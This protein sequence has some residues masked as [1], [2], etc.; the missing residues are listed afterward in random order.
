MAAY[1]GYD[2]PS[3]W[4]ARNYEH[5]SEV[6]AVESFFTKIGNK[7]NV[8]DIG[9]G[10][11]RLANT[12]SKFAKSITLVEPSRSLL[13][14]ARMTLKGQANLHLVNSTL[15]NMDSKIKAK[16]YDVVLLVRVMHHIKDPDDA[17]TA[18]SRHLDKGGYFI[19]EFANKLHGKAMLQ[20]L[21]NGNFTFP[22]DIFPLDKRSK[23]NI[24]NNSILFLNHHPDI[25][26]KSLKD[27][28]FTIVEKRSVS[29][30][31]SSALK[32]IAPMPILMSLEKLTQEPLA[33]I[34]FGPSIFILARKR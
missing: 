31:R 6:H 20:N 3:Y 32:S 13:T 22:L 7:K 21:L 18:A 4:D 30:V 25:V 19:V 23:K 14:R 33:K 1:D 8:V 34:N 29:N 17:I 27:H 26:E 5:L 15:Q 28:G 2:Y 11:G 24:K 9:A 10:F 12:Y 16:K